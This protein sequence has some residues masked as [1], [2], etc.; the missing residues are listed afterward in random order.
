MISK[1]LSTSERRAALHEVAPAGLAE[2]C[3]QLYPLLVAH[4]D[5]FGRLQGDAFTVK[6]AIDPTSPRL[7]PEFEIGLTALHTVKLI[8]WYCGRKYIQIQ[9]FDEHQQGL[10]KRTRSAFPEPPEPVADSGKYPDIPSELKG[11]EQK[12]T[13]R[14][15]DD[16]PA[17]QGDA[18]PTTAPP[19]FLEFPVVGKGGP[20]W[21]LSEAQVAEW[22]G[23]Y[24]MLDVRQA[25]RAALAWVKADLNRRKTAPGMLRF[26]NN[27]LAR[28]IRYGSVRTAP[29]ARPER[30]RGGW[31]PSSPV[32]VDCNHVEP[33]GSENFCA[34][35]K[36]NPNPAKYPVRPPVATR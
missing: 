12:R 21:G 28:E 2:F 9:N 20:V 22:A 4:S 3:Q 30:P 5:D 14:K 26:L 11:T 23:T 7:Q 35:L 34:H 31:E 15:K 6:H 24:P 16:S 36:K 1:S 32:P 29:A 18:V 25:C 8:Q 13:E 33:C 27:W 19:N 17:P 10:H